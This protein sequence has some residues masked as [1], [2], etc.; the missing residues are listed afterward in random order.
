MKTVLT[1]AALL[2]LAP[3]VTNER[4]RSIYALYFLID[5]CEAKLAASASLSRS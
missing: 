2:Y 3:L 5:I 1:R 4:K